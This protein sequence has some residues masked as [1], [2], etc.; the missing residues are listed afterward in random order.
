[1]FFFD[2][3]RIFTLGLRLIIYDFGSLF[4][5]YLIVKKQK[6]IHET[7]APELGGRSP[8]LIVYG[9]E[10][11]LPI[12]IELLSSDETEDVDTRIAKL[13][14]IRENTALQYNQKKNKQKNHYDQGRQS[15]KY[16]VGQYVMLYTPR[17]FKSLSKKL[18]C[19]W[20]GPYEILEVFNDYLN[21]KIRDP[22]SGKVQKAHVSR[23]KH[24]Y[25]PRDT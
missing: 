5:N 6:I 19:K 8:F 10:P 16:K 18:L 1:V 4:T 25:F 9:V 23:L 24:Y 20:I 3:K 7:L 15:V 2:P 14:L 22:R 21:Y 11:R 13:R 17:N 12:D